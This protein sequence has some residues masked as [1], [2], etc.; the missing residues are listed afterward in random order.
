MT[1]S[2]V[3]QIR[4]AKFLSCKRLMERIGQGT[5]Q[6]LDW[7]GATFEA[8]PDVSSDSRQVSHL[9]MHRRSELMQKLLCG[10]V[11]TR[12]QGFDGDAKQKQE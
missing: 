1:K 10:K 5:C 12:L 3:P 8:R 11:E 6:R 7:N 9:M 2:A 4:S